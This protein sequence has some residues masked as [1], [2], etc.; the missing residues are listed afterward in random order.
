MQSQCINTNFG[1]LR[2]RARRTRRFLCKTAETYAGNQSSRGRGGA[3]PARD[4]TITTI[5]RVICRGGIYAARRSH[6]DNATYRAT[7]AGRIYASPTN[8][9]EISVLPITAH[10]P[11]IRREGS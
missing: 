11:A 4:I 5:Y 9:S 2:V 8:L 1:V 10:P 7:P 3:F 6:P